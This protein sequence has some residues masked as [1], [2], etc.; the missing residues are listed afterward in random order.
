MAAGASEHQAEVAR[1]ERFEFGKNWARFLRVL[2][3]ERVALAEHSLKTMLKRDRLD[4]LSFLDVGSG[5][6]LF[7]FA[8]RR[9]GARVHSFDYDPNSVACTRE[10]RRRNFADDPDWAVEQGSVLD[11][12]YLA[13]LGIFDI[14]YSW[15]VLHHT[16]RM[17]EALDA[18]KPLVRM[19]GELFIAIYNDL[20]EV[21][22]E[23]ARIKQTYNQYPRPISTLYALTIIAREERK[24]LAAHLHQGGISA[25]LKSWTE[26]D[27][28][29]TRGMSKLHDWIDWIGGYPYERASVE[30]IADYFAK[31][32]FA[33]INLYERSG[34]YGCNE[35]VF[36][37]EA[38]LGTLIEAPI[39]GGKSLIRRFGLLLKGDP[40][41]TDLGWVIPA[42]LHR[43]TNGASDFIL[44]RDGLL[45]GS[46]SVVPDVRLI[47]AESTEPEAKLRASKFHLVWGQLRH[48]SEPFQYQRG[49]MWRWSLPE[50]ETL[51]DTNDNPHTSALFMFENG[52]QLPNP[53]ALH[54]DIALSGGRFSHWGTGIYF[55]PLERENP[56]SAISSYCAIIAASPSD[57]NR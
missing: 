33:L 54:D 2:N 42:P 6:G 43:S 3:D 53:H 31:D 9:L 36:R 28:S 7:S 50:F 19:N 22:D 26:Y 21:T 47:V 45:V 57:D 48:P 49:K 25:Y 39:P 17:W 16:G 24:S 5:S 18:V 12:D 11:H 20:G 13:S 44:F 30:A 4:G 37:R 1:G 52:K 8:A 38:P 46:G 34:G 51:A 41:L 35:F 56:N 14:V 10:L 32:G 29:S 15:G 55:S 27:R 23:W 40:E